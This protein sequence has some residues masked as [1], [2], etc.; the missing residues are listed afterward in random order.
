MPG[1]KTSH[2]VRLQDGSIDYQYYA[3]KGSMARNKEMKIVVGKVLGASQ[4][5]AHISPVLLTA[6][7][8]VLIL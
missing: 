8:L 7:L 1:K 2:I 5:T 4:I 3:A 6:I